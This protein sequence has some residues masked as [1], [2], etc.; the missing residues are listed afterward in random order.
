MAY[1]VA[2]GAWPNGLVPVI[3]GQRIV[4]SIYVTS[5]RCRAQ[6]FIAHYTKDGSNP[7][8]DWGNTSGIANNTADS[9]GT[10]ER[11]YGVMIVPAN[12]YAV[13]IRLRKY[14]TI[15]GET[16]SYL[17]MAGPQ[18]EVVGPS[19]STPSPY[20][21]GPPSDLTGLVSSGKITTGNASTYIANGA[22][23]TAQIAD[24]HAS[25]LTAYSIDTLQIKVG[26]V[27]A[28]QKAVS[29]GY[30]WT[31]GSSG[32]QVESV[33]WGASA[34]HLFNLTVGNGTPIKFSG[35]VDLT[36]LFNNLN[37]WYANIRLRLFMGNAEYDIHYTTQKVFRD[38]SSTSKLQTI[39]PWS[40]G[41]SFVYGG[42]YGFA[43]YAEI[44]FKTESG[45]AAYT[46]GVM[47]A[48]IAAYAEENKV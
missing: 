30:I 38:G 31:V 41:H 7:S 27:T 18:V 3:P 2:C 20:M 25:K 44:W 34:F 6:I 4:Y 15:S 37:P 46:W 45:D 10:Y 5:H 29:T 16:N 36:I 22:F 11:L 1:D 48:S 17:W 32:A 33:N 21:S 24:L 26:A 39:I 47:D 43:I 35:T 19:V 12:I 8:W 23:G 42:T 28:S 40:V 13:Q 9:L 14:N